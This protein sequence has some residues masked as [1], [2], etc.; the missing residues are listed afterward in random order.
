MKFE[1]PGYPNMGEHI[2][3]LPNIAELLVQPFWGSID[4]EDLMKHGTK[5]QKLILEKA[6]ITNTR[7]YVCVTVSTQ[8]LYPGVI[9][10]PNKFWSMPEGE[11]HRDGNVDMFYQ[12][13]DICHLFLSDCQAMTEWNVNPIE[14]DIPEG[15]TP[16]QVINMVNFNPDQFGLKG[17]KQDPNRFVTFTNHFHRV[18]LPNHYQFRYMYRIIESDHR[19]P[20]PLDQSYRRNSAVS[21]LSQQPNGSAPNITKQGKEKRIIID[22]SAQ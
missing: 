17:R 22:Y 5:L 20:N 14:I 11:W 13:P 6:P 15:S 9:S 10:V 12:N 2:I 7:K 8:M 16:E 3:E 18:T 1:I 21:P 4:A 19:K